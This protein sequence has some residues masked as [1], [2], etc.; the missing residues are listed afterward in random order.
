M[1][2]AQVHAQ[3]FEDDPAIGTVDELQTTAVLTEVGTTKATVRG[4]GHS[5][6]VPVPAA[7]VSGPQRR[8]KL[9]RTRHP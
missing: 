6:A 7:I 9:L 8:P 1:G 5:R 2:I 3:A 4:H